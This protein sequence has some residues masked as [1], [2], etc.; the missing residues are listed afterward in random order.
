M[1]VG[2]AGTFI[3]EVPPRWGN[4]QYIGAFSVTV[5]QLAVL[6]DV[7]AFWWISSVWL[8]VRSRRALKCTII[9]LHFAIQ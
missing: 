6:L 8:P 3:I 4:H 1:G 9:P 2:H 7:C 5:M